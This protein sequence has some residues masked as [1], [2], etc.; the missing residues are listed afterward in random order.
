[1]NVL[2]APKSVHATFDAGVGDALLAIVLLY[3]RF[4]RYRRGV[5]AGGK[6]PTMNTF[7]AIGQLALGAA[8]IIWTI[9]A[10]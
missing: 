2:N 10:F 6:L 9:K 8:A 3:L 4:E 5:A 7:S 1:L